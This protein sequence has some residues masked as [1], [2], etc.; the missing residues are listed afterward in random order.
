MGQERVEKLEE[1]EAVLRKGGWRRCPQAR[2]TETSM[3]GCSCWCIDRDDP[4]APDAFVTHYG[5]AL[6]VPHGDLCPPSVLRFPRY[7][8]EAEYGPAF[9][10]MRAFVERSR[11]HIAHGDDPT[12]AAHGERE[13]GRRGRTTH[14]E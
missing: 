6:E 11:L 7:S 2:G 3:P 14:I 5:Y 4:H 1:G 8:G 12:T 10:R 9:E 13:G